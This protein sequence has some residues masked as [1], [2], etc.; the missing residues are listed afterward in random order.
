MVAEARDGGALVHGR[1][2]AHG[3]RDGAADDRLGDHLA[4]HAAPGA[5]GDGRARRAGGRGRGGS[6]SGSGP[7][8]SSSTTPRRRRT[9]AR[10]HARRG[11][12]RARRPRRR[13]VR[14]RRRD[15]ERVGSR[16]ARGRRVAAWGAARLH[17]RDGAED[18][19]ARGRDRRRLPHAVDHDTSIRALHAGERRGRHRHRLHVVA[20]IDESDRAAGRE[21]ARE[22]AGMYLAN[23]F[24]NI[25]GSA[26][27]LLELAGI[28][29]GRA[30]SGR[31]GDGARRPARG[32][33]GGDG[34]APRQLQADRGHAGGLHRGDRGVPRRGLHA[35][36]ARAL[37]RGRHEQ[38]RLFGERVLPHVRGVGCGLRIDGERLVELALRLVRR[39]RSPAPRRRRRS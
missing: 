38:I 23:K 10:A 22:I 18:A 16:A 26:D 5:G 19:G 14:V 17:R 30:G 25:R 29:D 9:D 32:G 21:G 34:L 35:R 3:A 1:V 4:V 20:S 11:L 39:R 31:G 8:R 36:H 33:R 7:R 13:R 6:C 27:T 15:V 12:D 37:G 2:G 24:Q 28:E